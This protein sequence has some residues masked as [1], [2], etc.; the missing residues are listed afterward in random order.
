M[1]MSKCLISIP[2]ETRNIGLQSF[3]V[4][5]DFIRDPY[6]ETLKNALKKKIEEHGRIFV[7]ARVGKDNSR[8]IP[9][10]ERSNFYFVETILVPYTT[11]KTNSVLNRFIANKSEFLPAQ[12]NC[13]DLAV[14]PVNK[15]DNSLCLRIKEIATESFS[16]D[17]FHI[18]PQCS[19]ETANARFSFWVDDLFADKQVIFHTI[20]YLGKAQGF[21]ARK[22][23]N[24]ILTC[25]SKEFIGKGLAKFFWLRVLE[26]MLNEG[27]SQTHTLI[28]TNNTPALNLYTRLGFKF[29][30]PAVPLH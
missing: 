15:E 16:D 20:N 28:S 30:N 6:E 9:L 7:Q 12:Y 27:F 8:A 19:E 23:D 5:E 10:L 18:D 24:L 21:I 29:K 25:F 22:S 13:N 4:T 26:D 14:V 11:L 17:R 2:W 1:A 3:E